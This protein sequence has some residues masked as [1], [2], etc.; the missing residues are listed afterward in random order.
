MEPR[1]TACPNLPH[2]YDFHLILE[3]Q[4]T[5]VQIIPTTP[6]FPIYGMTVFIVH[7]VEK[8]E[9]YMMIHPVK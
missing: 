8:K 4:Y 9:K 7:E 1:W 6:I 5:F 2:I 3:N